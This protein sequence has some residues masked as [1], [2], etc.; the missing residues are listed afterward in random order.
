MTRLYILLYTPIVLLS[1]LG[2]MYYGV[3]GYEGLKIQ[4]ETGVISN[5]G[6]S[7]FKE[8]YRMVNTGI[9]PACF[10]WLVYLASKKPT[11]IAFRVQV[12]YL[13]VL[14]II[15]KLSDHMVTVIKEY[16]GNTFLYDA[17]TYSSIS[18]WLLM[19]YIIIVP[20]RINYLNRKMRYYGR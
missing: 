17:Y 20:I 6:L 1:A 19:A 13:T 9:A 4:S 18:A 5:E 14:F 3:F 10:M 16:S 11:T 7:L 2:Y 12:F 8:I 15:P